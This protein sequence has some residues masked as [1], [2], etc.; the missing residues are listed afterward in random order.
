MKKIKGTV[1]LKVINLNMLDRRPISL[2]AVYERQKTDEKGNLLNA[3]EESLKEFFFR[4]VTSDELLRLRLNRKPA[5]VYKID[6]RYYYT[7]IPGNLKLIRLSETAGPHLCGKN[8]TNVCK[9]CPKTYDLTT[10]FQE[11]MGRSF[12]YT[13]LE[14]WRIEKYDF[15]TEGLEAFNMFNQNDAFVVLKCQDYKVSQPRLMTVN[16]SVADLKV[17]L[18][19]FWWDDF[20]GTLT[21]MRRRIDSHKNQK[22]G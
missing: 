9:D 1:G 10:S 2:Q 16:K 7:E 22:V 20:D 5:A 21:D 4:E 12:P 15:V 6:G 17:G 11:R 8:C 18:A 3:M 19:N 13:V 14:S